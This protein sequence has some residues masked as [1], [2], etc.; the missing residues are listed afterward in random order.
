[1]RTHPSPHIP[2]RTNVKNA[3]VATPRDVYEAPGMPAPSQVE[4]LY[5][6]YR[7]PHF[8]A[9]AKPDENSEAANAVTGNRRAT[10]VILMING[11]CMIN[12]WSE[13]RPGAG[14]G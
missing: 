13:R 4:H 2:R 10:D 1:M 11:D 9:R 14:D 6:F 7:S 12:G 3:S 8:G 5:E